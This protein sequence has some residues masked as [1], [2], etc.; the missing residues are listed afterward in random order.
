M[1]GAGFLPP[2]LLHS[3]HGIAKY[4]CSK[5]PI[6]C[7]ANFSGENIY[8]SFWILMQKKNRILMNAVL[9]MCLARA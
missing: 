9:V 7:E 4:M 3:D 6:I 8:T 5:P 1:V 2:S